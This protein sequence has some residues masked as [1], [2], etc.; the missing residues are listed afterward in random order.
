MHTTPVWWSNLDRFPASDPRNAMHRCQ[1][2]DNLFNYEALDQD[3][4]CPECR[5]EKD[6]D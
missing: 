2:C 6:E 1:W 5:P 3:G 4:L